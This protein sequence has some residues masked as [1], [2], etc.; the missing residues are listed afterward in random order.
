MYDVETNEFLVSR[1]VVLKEDVFPYKEAVSTQV[2]ESNLTGGLDD[3]WIID[4][5]SDTADRG[6]DP[7]DVVQVTKEKQGV[8][9]TEEEDSQVDG[10]SSNEATQ[11]NEVAEI[12][13]TNDSEVAAI[14]K[15]NDSDTASG[16]IIAN[17]PAISSEETKEPELGRGLREKTPSVKLRDYISHNVVCIDNPHHDLTSSDPESSMK[18]SG[19]HS[20]PYPLVNFVSDEKFLEAHKAFLAAV[21]KGVAPK[22]YKKA[23]QLKVWWD[24]MKDEMDAFELNKTFS[25]VDLRPGKEAI[26][27]M[28]LYKYKYG[29]DVMIKKHKYMLVVL[30]NRQV[31]GVNFTEAFAPV[32]KMTTIR[33][34]LRVVAGKGWIIHQ[35]DVQNAFLHGELKEKVYMKLPQG[36][37]HSDPK[38]VCRLPKDVYGL[39]QAP[40]YWY[41]KLTE[42]LTKYGFKHSYEDYSLFM[43]TKG[44]VE[45]RVLIYIDDLLVCGNDM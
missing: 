17:Q 14:K 43:Y 37:T 39:K 15:T 40:K 19:T 8:A 41:E 18:V 32:A 1:D 31:E 2:D 6:N 26:G 13:M 20:T 33:S 29:A 5:A 42:A 25:I 16:G 3:D 30:G 10:E 36:F 44:N 34:L 27:N 45:I 7:I 23:V 11:K 28:W 35:M 12:N 38:K 9:V 4:S 24:S 21:T 22:S